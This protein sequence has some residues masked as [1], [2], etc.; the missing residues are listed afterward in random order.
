MRVSAD[1]LLPILLGVAI[2]VGG[3]MHGAH[4]GAMLPSNGALD[5]VE[6]VALQQQ[7]DQLTKE[8]EALRSLSQGG[9]EFSVPPEFIERVEKQL[10]LRFVST[11]VVHQVAIEELPDRVLA[12]MEARYGDGGLDDRQIAYRLIGWLRQEDRLGHQLAALRAVGARAWFDEFS[13]EAWVTNRFQMANIPDQASLLRA[14]AR[15][16]LNQHFPAAQGQITDEFVRTRDALHSGVGAGVESKFFQENARA[17]G[18][19]SLKEDN[20]AAQLMLS[21]PPFLQGLASFAGIEGKTYADELLVKGSAELLDKLR[22]PPQYSAEIMFPYEREI[23]TQSLELAETPGEMV[24]QDAAGALGLRLWFDR[25]GDVKESRD[26]AEELVDDRW[27]LFA[28]DDQTFHLVWV[29]AFKDKKSAERATNASLSML[30]SFVES[31]T[32]PVIGA[33]V[34]TSEGRYLRVDRISDTQIR[35]INAADQ[36]MMNQVK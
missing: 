19:M 1:R 34:K 12:S 17:I 28:T 9:G 26:L 36:A 15:I 24:I 10:G 8:N 16:L 27:R 11:P 3:W 25:L 6:L 7:V 35:F 20:E 4:N 31:T 5:A 30:A 21:L 29:M 2:A 18:F 13:G 22:K 23:A 33:V 32:E 14:L